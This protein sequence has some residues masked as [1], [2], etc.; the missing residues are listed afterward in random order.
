MMLT[1]M[2]RTTLLFLFPAALFAD[3]AYYYSGLQTNPAAWT[4]NGS[5][6]SADGGSQISSIA[7]P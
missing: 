5:F 7:V 6:A 4:I 2:T 1:Q 3:Y